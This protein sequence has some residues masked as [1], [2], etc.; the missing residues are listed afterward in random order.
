VENVRKLLDPMFKWQRKGHH[1]IAT[2]SGRR[3][4][5]WVVGN[6]ETPIGTQEPTV[7]QSRVIIPGGGHKMATVWGSPHATKTKGTTFVHGGMDEGKGGFHTGW[8]GQGP[9]VL[10]GNK[11]KQA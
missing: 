4:R 1:P 6:K 8:G 2:R 3:E 11:K 5:H 9:P 10:R 7:G